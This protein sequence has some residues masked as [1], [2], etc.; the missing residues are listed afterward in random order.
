[1]TKHG[2]A[3]LQ[4]EKSSWW[5]TN[6]EVSDAPQLWQL[7]LQFSWGSS[8]AV[9]AELHVTARLW[10]AQRMG[11]QLAKPGKTFSVYYTCTSC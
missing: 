6:P 5:V 11:R 9:E 10:G 8:T 2:A 7:N 4:A 1:M 3:L